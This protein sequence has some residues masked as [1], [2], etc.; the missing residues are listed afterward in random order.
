MSV[1]LGSKQ[2]KLLLRIS[3]EVFVQRVLMTAM[4][5]CCPFFLERRSPAGYKVE[6]LDFQNRVCHLH[7]I[8]LYNSYA[9]L[10]VLP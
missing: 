8:L 1:R 5:Q 6:W 7:Y 4:Q 2:S 10:Q 9:M 3:H